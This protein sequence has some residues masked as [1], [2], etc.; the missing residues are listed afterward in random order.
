M[1]DKG[2]KL[3]HWW[4]NHVD[5]HRKKGVNPVEGVDFVDRANGLVERRHATRQPDN[6]RTLVDRANEFVERRHPTRQP[7]TFRTLVD[8]ANEFVERR[9]TT[10]QPDI[11]RLLDVD[12]DIANIPQTNKKPEIDRLLI[13]DS[14]N[15]DDG[16]QQMGPRCFLKDKK[17]SALN[18]NASSK[19]PIPRRLKCCGTQTPRKVQDDK[20]VDALEQQ[21]EQMK[22]REKELL[23]RLSKEKDC[24]D[25][26][27]TYCFQLL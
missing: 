9:N 2:Y 20:E 5:S 24:G 22:L 14:D 15:D 19:I 7:G 16:Q 17:K 4:D 3:Q 6:V 27:D 11:D 8:R 21:L 26:D 23:R 12:Y 1:C 18:E 10:R 13:L 25:Y